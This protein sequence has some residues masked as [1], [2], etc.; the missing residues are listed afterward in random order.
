MLKRIPSEYLN[1]CIFIYQNLRLSEISNYCD[2][3]K[4][5]HY[6]SITNQLINTIR[7]YNSNKKILV[8]L[9]GSIVFKSDFLEHFDYTINIHPGL[10]P[11]QA[12]N[13]TASW[14]IRNEQP[15]GTSI[16]TIEDKLDGG[17]LYLEACLW[18]NN[19]FEPAYKRQDRLK[20]Q[21]L[22]L[23]SSNI[24]IIF[25]NIETWYKYV[26]TNGTYKN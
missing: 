14:S 7:E 15:A 18:P 8:N 1:N 23:I 10:L 4:H 26:P 16:L 17:L 25:C 21:M 11:S 20:A 2:I 13:H 19:F 24:E 3:S 12:G 5:I 9:W 22:E 6:Q